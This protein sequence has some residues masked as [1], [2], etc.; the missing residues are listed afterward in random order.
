[1]NLD[2]IRKL[3]PLLDHAEDMVAGEREG[4]KAI[5]DKAKGDG[6]RPDALKVARRIQKM[7]PTERHAW[8]ETFDAAR[9]AMALDAQGE[10][11]DAIKASRPL[12][13]A[14]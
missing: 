10:L 6:I 1:M 7:A 5:Y 2:S 8:F 12:A 14:A 9:E 3:N 4:V 11:E 13:G